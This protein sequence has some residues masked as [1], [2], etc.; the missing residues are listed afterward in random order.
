MAAPKYGPQTRADNGRRTVLSAGSDPASS[1]WARKGAFLVRHYSPNAPGALR[2]SGGDP[3]PRAEAAA[4]WGEP[5]PKT[6]KD[7]AALYA[8]GQRML[9]RHRKAKE[10]R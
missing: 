10:A 6:D 1:A 3:T 7:R 5:V 9:E 2:D 4:R 8:K